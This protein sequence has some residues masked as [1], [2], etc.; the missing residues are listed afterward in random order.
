MPAPATLTPDG[1]DGCA[2][3]RPECALAHASGWVLA[4]CWTG[5]GGVSFVNPSTARTH[6]LLARDRHPAFGE[7]LRPNGIALDADGRL[8]LAHLGAE[9]G[10]VFELL[11][12]GGVRSLVDT[13]DGAPMPPANFVVADRVGRL[14]I[15]VSTRCV[16]RSVDYRRHAASGFIAVLERGATDARLV[17]DGLGYTNEC[18]VDEQR[19]QVYVNETFAR[20]L[21]V[22][23]LRADGTLGAR[24]TLA[25]FGAGS[26]PDGLALDAEGCLW[27][28]SIVSNRVLRVT[29]DGDVTTILEDSDPEHVAWAEA[30]WEA[31]AL[32]RQHLDK[33]AGQRLANVSNL[34]FGG[35]D[36]RTVWLGN[37][38]GSTLPRY[39]ASVPGAPMVHTRAPLT[40]LLPPPHD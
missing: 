17:A 19:Q 40:H 5:A 37:L 32:G 35:D 3:V 30:A 15:T 39:R 33:A 22:F 1:D 6:H 24:R 21:S 2:L 14:W 18:V 26:Y 8:L 34:A 12:G 16:P 10:A 11:P 31:D 25:R 38:L 23:A 13:V 28:T 20:R 36:L 7:P 9:R 29:P 4:P 27:V